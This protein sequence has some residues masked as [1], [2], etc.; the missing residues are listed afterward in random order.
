[1]CAC[2]WS[3]EAYIPRVPLG[4]VHQ[5]KQQYQQHV[6]GVL[7]TSHPKRHIC[8]YIKWEMAVRFKKQRRAFTNVLIAF[9]SSLRNSSWRFIIVSKLHLACVVRQLNG[10]KETWCY[11]SQ[12]T[13]TG[14]KSLAAPMIFWPM[15]LIHST[16]RCQS[17]GTSL[18][19]GGGGTRIED[20]K[21]EYV[22][23][24]V[25]RTA[26]NA[27]RRSRTQRKLRRL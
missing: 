27:G 7:L 3:Y 9:V 26:C 19:W 25:R 5:Q 13:W 6:D 20:R 12:L 8:W 18:I 23:R 2:Q 24:R 4:I 10:R 11:S 14:R 21:D 15:T 22:C 17:G 16:R 1:M